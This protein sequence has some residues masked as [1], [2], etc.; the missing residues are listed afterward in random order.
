MLF[1]EKSDHLNGEAKAKC[2][3]YGP[4]ETSPEHSSTFE[5]TLKNVALFH[6][7]CFVCM[8]ISQIIES[9][10]LHWVHYSKFLTLITIP[11]YIT[12]IFNIQ[13]ALRVNNSWEKKWNRR[14]NKKVDGN[15]YKYD[16]NAREHC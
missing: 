4:K 6:M 2:P 15:K 16:A 9:K 8:V 3:H 13:E 11:M 1:R 12:I 7:L 14:L 5:D 10:N